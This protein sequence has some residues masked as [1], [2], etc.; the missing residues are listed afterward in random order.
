FV[1]GRKHELVE[2]SPGT[3]Y[4]PH[5]TSLRMGPLGYQSDAQSA[6]RVS[7]NDLKSYAASLDDAL[8]KPYPPYAKAGIRDNDN[9][10]QLSTSLL[11]IE[12]EFYGSIRPKRRINS[13]ERALHAL[14]ERGVEYVEVRLMDLDPF[15][16]IGIWP[17]TCRF[18]DLFLLHCLLADSPPDTTQEIAAIRRNQQRVALR[19][20]E[21]GLKLQKD[22]DELELV[23]WGGQILSECAPIAEALDQA[24]GGGSAHRDALAAALQALRTSDSVPS[25]KVLQAM[26]REHRN[27]FV[28]FALAESTLHKASLKGHELPREANERFTGLADWSLER[29]REIEAADKVPF[30]AW[31][32]KYLSHDTLVV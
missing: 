30:E 15:C 12:N 7:Y 8:T 32:Q 17:A 20:R 28:R 22:S 11:Q 5:A 10:R 26:A 16:P 19:G 13:G 9:Y 6:L 2:L 23:R 21:P 27:S 24:N 4:A 18:L 31:R 14:R 29:Q 1:E 25:A 3:M